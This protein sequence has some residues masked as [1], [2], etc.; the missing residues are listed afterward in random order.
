MV[1]VKTSDA[2]IGEYQDY[3]SGGSHD[4][5]RGI[6]GL[7]ALR[8]IEAL[9]PDGKIGRFLDVGCGEG[10]LLAFASRANLATQYYGVEISDS[11]IK[12]TLA[13]QISGVVEVKKF[14]GY[15]IP[16]PDKFFDFAVATHVIEHVEHERLFVAEIARVSRRFY[17]ETPLEDTIKI[18]RA[19]RIGK[20]YG[21]INF[22]SD[23]RLLD[24]LRTTAGVAGVG[25]HRVFSHDLEY[26]VHL[27][28]P[29]VGAVK[30]W[31]RRSLL[32]FAPKLA[33]R[34]LVYIIGV[35]CDSK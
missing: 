5:K 27:A 30:H 22:Y 24:L 8:H 25:P 15:H 23:A 20:E 19:I 33:K 29:F 3:Y 4:A 14:D 28:G 11:G 31:V 21:H 2:L 35:I 7:Q 1:E 9:L 34:H 12:E 32:R 13:K 6:A 17:I 18:D 10:S 26:E 16:Y